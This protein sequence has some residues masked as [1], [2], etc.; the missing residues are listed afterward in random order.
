MQLDAIAPR[1]GLYEKG[2]TPGNQVGP[3]RPVPL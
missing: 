3:D 1:Y 2:S